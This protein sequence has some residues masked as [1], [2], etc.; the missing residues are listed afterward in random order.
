M[1]APVN[2]IFPKPTSVAVSPDG[3]K[4]WVSQA[5]MFPVSPS[6]D[7]LYVFDASTGAQLAHI[8]VGQGAYFMTLLA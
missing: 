2:T 5:D 8:E 3:T 1:T 7:F 4:V 6:S